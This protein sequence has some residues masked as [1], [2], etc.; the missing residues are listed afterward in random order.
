MEAYNVNNYNNIVYIEP[1]PLNN[2]RNTQKYIN[3]IN[4]DR[5]SRKDLHNLSTQIVKNIIKCY[6]RNGNYLEYVT[7][8]IAKWTNEVL[9]NKKGCIT[10]LECWQQELT[11]KLNNIDEIN[12]T[13]VFKKYDEYYI[14]AVGSAVDGE[15]MRKCN[16][17]YFDTL[18]EFSVVNIVEFLA[19]SENEVSNFDIPTDA[20]V[21]SKGDL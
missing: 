11:T 21:L 5:Y 15:L 10:M 8:G 20:V 14:Y 4:I 3:N 13:I 19:I 12:R 1:R 7:N 9:N 6:T 16:N 2:I 17:I 18:D